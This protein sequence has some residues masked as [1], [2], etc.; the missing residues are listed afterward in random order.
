MSRVELVKF[1]IESNFYEVPSIEDLMSSQ[2][3]R[4]LRDKLIENESLSLAMEVTTKCGLDPGAVWGAWGLAYLQ[5]G[6]FKE[7]RKKF[8]KFLKPS[9]RGKTTQGNQRYLKMI[10][11]ILETSLMLSFDYLI[12]VS[13]L[14]IELTRLRQ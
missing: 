4:R 2:S 8:N 6:Q 9:E 7:A 5:V 1:L 11:D 12:V 3:A 10:I 13:T 14:L